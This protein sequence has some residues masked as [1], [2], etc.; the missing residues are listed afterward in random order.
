MKYIWGSLIAGIL[1]LGIINTFI[2]RFGR[3]ADYFVILHIVLTLA[4]LFRYKPGLREILIFAFLARIAL[5]VWD[6]NFDHIF[7][8]PNSGS[9]SVMYYNSARQVSDD[10][11][12]LIQ[13]IRGGIFSK[14]TGTVFWFT[15]FSRAMGQYINVLLGLAIVMLM[16]IIARMLR[17]GTRS[18]RTV[19]LV[20]AFFPNSMVMS[21]IFLREIFPA[22]F[23]AASLYFFCRW[24]IKPKVRDI[25]LTL[26]MLALASMFHSGVMG[27][28][29][30]YAYAFL[31]YKYQKRKFTF[32]PRTIFSLMILTV[33]VYLATNV[34]QDQLFGKFQGVEEMEDIY[35]T[36]NSRLGASAYLRGMEINS[37]WQFL[38]Y[39][40]IKML[41]FL[42]AP[43]PMDWRGGMD[44]FTFFADSLL[45]LYVCI[46]LFKKRKMF[47]SHKP[48]VTTLTLMLLGA[49]LIF[50]IGVS[51]AGSAVRHRQK[52]IPIFLV[53]MG[54]L[55]DCSSH[56]RF[57]SAAYRHRVYP[58]DTGTSPGGNE[59]R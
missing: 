19:L 47:G 56:A 35:L 32:T 14:I 58:N 57:N 36:A 53:S 54:I 25:L 34:F 2:I 52:L 42:I 44:I 43:V 11:S 45:Y 55:I 27:I 16:N 51:N 21:A 28:I 20:A 41:Y 29:L 23:V 26:V 12:L 7:S 22:F 50:G 6:I 33:S 30:G 46:T 4:L 9:D 40:P 3:A 39:G 13:D 37:L 31:F 48:L 10:L 8:L 15:G 38:V 18:R 5:M 17:L 1:G 49:V 24:F 59:L